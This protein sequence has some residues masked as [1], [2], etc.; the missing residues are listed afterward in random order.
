MRLI[1]GPLAFVYPMKTPRTAYPLVGG[2]Q[3]IAVHRDNRGGPWIQ[4]M[5]TTW[6]ALMDIP[7]ELGGLAVL[8]GSHTYVPAGGVEVENA[9]ELL[10]RDDD[11]NWVTTDYGSGDVLIF[12]CYT[13]HKGMPNKSDRV[14]LSVDNRW[15]TTDHPVH[16][17][18]LHPYHYFDKYPRIPNWDELSRDWKTKR[19]IEYPPNVQ[20]TITKWPRG[21][22]DL[23]PSSRFFD[24]YRGVRGGWRP[25]TRDT[26][27]YLIASP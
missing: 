21:A 14:R 22:D 2:G 10:V 18:V 12:H 1:L 26:T 3:P 20:A 5:F 25:A 7:R 8:R 19:W 16:V 11:P 27:P 24:I 13:V 17:S 4:D 6:I 15:Q 23:V 9:E